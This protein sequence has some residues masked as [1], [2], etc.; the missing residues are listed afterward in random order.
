M[1]RSDFY[2][3]SNGKTITG[4]RLY[5]AIYDRY[6]ADLDEPIHLISDDTAPNPG[7]PVDEFRMVGG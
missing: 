6:F 3:D 2:T 5:D 1:T 7:Y 4:D